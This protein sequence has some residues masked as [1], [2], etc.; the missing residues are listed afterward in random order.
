MKQIDKIV[1]FCVKKAY[2]EPDRAP[3]LRYALEK[4]LVSILSFVPLTAIGL[5]LTDCKVFL[6]FIISFD[7]LRTTTNGWH[8]RSFVVCLMC[9][10]VGECV[11]LGVF[12]HLW[13]PVTS[14]LGVIL[15]AAIIWKYAPYNHPNMNL[16]TEE[17]MACRR[18]ARKRL[19]FL[20]I[21]SIVFRFLSVGELSCG[22]DLG[23]LQV[24]IMLILAY[25]IK[26]KSAV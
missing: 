24:A 18:A 11:F 7:L 21:C 22:I 16:S 1:D 25:M 10:I 13:N 2:L 12:S 26:A 5:L 19:V 4:R 9:S 23:I 20:I 3:W 14:L 8:A 6:S 17:I 15:S